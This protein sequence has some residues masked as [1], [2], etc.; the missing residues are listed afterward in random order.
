MCRG[1]FTPQLLFSS[2]DQQVRRIRSPFCFGPDPEEIHFLASLP[3]WKLKI[4]GFTRCCPLIKVDACGR[5]PP[6]DA[7]QDINDVRAPFDAP[8]PRVKLA[9]SSAAGHAVYLFF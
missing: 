2:L 6:R 1:S 9:A 5:F 4:N 3:G 8:E 7:L